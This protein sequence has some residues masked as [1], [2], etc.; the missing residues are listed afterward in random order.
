LVRAL[1]RESW[2]LAFA[3]PFFAISFALRF[4]ASDLFDMPFSLV[5]TRRC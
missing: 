3:R 2:T 1:A 5:D 4:I